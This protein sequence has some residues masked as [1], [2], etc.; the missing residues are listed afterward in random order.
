HE[1]LQEGGGFV[2]QPLAVPPDRRVQLLDL[3]LPLRARAV[4]VPADAVPAVAAV[5]AP[6]GLARGVVGGDAE[7]GQAARTAG[8]EAPQQVVVAGG[9]FGGEDPGAAPVWGRLVGC[10]IHGDSRGGGRG[11]PPPRGRGGGAPRGGGGAGGAAG[12]PGRRGGWGSGGG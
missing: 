9:V 4:A 7:H 1:L 2:E 12:A 11:P 3:G 8:E 5:V 6:P 10:G